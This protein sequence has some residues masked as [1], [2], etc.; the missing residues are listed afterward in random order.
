MPTPMSDSPAPTRGSRFAVQRAELLLFV[1]A[2]LAGFAL[3]AGS[4]RAGSY[5][6]FSCQHPDGSPAPA[7]GWSE[8]QADGGYTQSCVG[9][10][11][12]LAALPGGRQSCRGL[13]DVVLEPSR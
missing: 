7:D 6:L 11:W 8:N 13:R 5:V 4:A 1:L 12:M 3:L 2:A 10:S 9:R